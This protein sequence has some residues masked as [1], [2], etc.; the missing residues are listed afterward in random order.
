MS[1]QRPSRRQLQTRREFLG[2]AGVTVGGL[3]L[4]S[5]FLA[6]CSSDKKSSTAGGA[7]VTQDTK[8]LYF[9]NWPSYID[10]KTVANFEKATGIKMNY[11]EEIND[12]DELFAKIKPLLSKGK[13]IDQDLIAPTFWMVGRLIRLGWVDKLLSR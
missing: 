7:A 1:N 9:A 10:D 12:N 13:V 3:A 2:R 4:G 5:D 11:T 8:N 6:A